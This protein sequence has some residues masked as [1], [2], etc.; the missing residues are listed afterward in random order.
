M[1]IGYPPPAQWD[2]VSDGS[3]RLYKML[4]GTEVRPTITSE[5]IDWGTL[6]LIPRWVGED[7]S[8]AVAAIEPSRYFNRGAAEWERFITGA[9]QR[10]EVALAVSMIGHPGSSENSGMGGLPGVADARVA[11]PGSEAGSIGGFH[12]PLAEAPSVANGLGRADRDLAMR[13]VNARGSATNWWTLHYNAAI[14]LPGDGGPG[15]EVQPDGSLQPLLVSAVG[16]VVAAVWVSADERLRHY[17]IPY[18]KS[19]KVVL[20][21]LA[22]HAVPEFVPSAVRRVH[23]NLGEDPALQTDAEKAALAARAKLDEQ[24]RI[25]SEQLEQTLRG[26]RAAADEVRFNLLYG[27]STSLENA[28]AAVLTD[29]GMTVV[30]LDSDL[31]NTASADMLV[32]D[33]ARHRLVEVKSESGNASEKH[34]G[35][36]QKHLATWPALR[37]DV[38]VEGVS[39]IINHQTKIYPGERTDQAYTRPEFVQSLTIPVITATALYDAWRRH[40]FGAIRAAVFGAAL[41]IGKSAVDDRSQQPAVG[42]PEPSRRQRWWRPTRNR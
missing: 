37:P 7:T 13:L 10:Q 32:S 9:R 14:I 21:W 1:H 38:E 18:L 4:G 6:G 26:A 12:T 27:R 16:E 5:Q 29:A 2:K 40:D 15:R 34:V 35:D 36:A 25:Q 41:S 24:Y 22:Q 33:G 30:P 8:G 3:V 28:V 11:L 23:A 39:L 17:V 42:V 19:W 31:K 20:D